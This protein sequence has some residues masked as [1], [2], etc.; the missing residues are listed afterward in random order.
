MALAVAAVLGRYTVPLL[1]LESWVRSLAEEANTR[2]LLKL[3]LIR[4]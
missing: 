4:L 1:G 2:K 3:A